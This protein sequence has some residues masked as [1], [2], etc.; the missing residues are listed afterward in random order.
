MKRRSFTSIDSADRQ[1]EI[2]QNRFL[3][4]LA[5]KAA[6][7]K[8]RRN[9]ARARDA[10]QCWK[11]LSAKSKTKA[12]LR[13]AFDPDVSIHA[14]LKLAAVTL[15]NEENMRG[16]V[17]DLG[18]A[19][20][21]GV[22]RPAFDDLDRTIVSLWNGWSRLK[23]KNRHD[24]AILRNLPKLPTW[25]GSA[26]WKFVKMFVRQP[27]LSFET[28]RQRLSKLGLHV[29]TPALVLSYRPRL[30]KLGLHDGKSF[31]VTYSP[32][33]ARWFR[34]NAVT[35]KCKISS[36]DKAMM[37]GVNGTGETPGTYL[38]RS[39]NGRTRSTC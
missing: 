29:Q 21:R 11:S 20:S 8:E 9:L 35:Q 25:S 31:T 33:G 32:E 10:I 23:I 4:C 27:G 2:Y 16:F 13:A 39:R 5:A 22:T 18:I 36:Q 30:S 15:K 37:P 38:A 34:E 24:A 6:S 3:F 17:R 7:A 28:Y 14:I 1:F 19:I 26:A 12:L